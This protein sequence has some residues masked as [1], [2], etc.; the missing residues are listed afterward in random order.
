MYYSQIQQDKW[1][2]EEIFPGVT[3]GFF[4]DVG[5]ADG[6][7]F[8]NTL[9]LEE[10]GWAGL[11]IEPHPELFPKLE[12]NRPNSHCVNRCVGN[13]TGFVD[14]C[15][16]DLDPLLSGRVDTLGN[17]M[18]Q[19]VT[20]KIIRIES[21]TLT[22]ILEAFKVPRMPQQ[23]HYMSLDVEGAEMEVLRGLDFSK[24]AFKAITVEHNFHPVLRP[25]IRH[26]L[27]QHEYILAKECQWDDY[28]I[29]GS[30][31]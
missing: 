21:Q 13:V 11:C 20:G 26:I 23:M 5:A 16:A 3:N 30:M 4:V 29:H 1:I 17:Y 15:V 25:Q 12:N 27:E 19:K 7:R 28:Y 2:I 18:G 24:Y 10:L 22:S 6:V 8:S 14:F 31:L 9:A